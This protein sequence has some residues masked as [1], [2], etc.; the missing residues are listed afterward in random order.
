L[1]TGWERAEA[2]LKVLV[3]Q[4]VRENA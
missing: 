4:M 3:E 1:R 2:R